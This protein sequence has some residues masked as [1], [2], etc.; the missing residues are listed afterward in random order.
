MIMRRVWCAFR[1]SLVTL[2][3]IGVPLRSQT[4]AQATVA[5]YYNDKQRMGHNLLETTLT[6]SNVNSTHFG[7][8]FSQG[9][10]G[11]IY[12]QPLYVPNVI[13]AG[14]GTHNVVFVA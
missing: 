14:L 3:C 2:V 11:F 13:V 9:V 10:D 1:A 7:K 5:T 6:P 8:L 12:A 4:A